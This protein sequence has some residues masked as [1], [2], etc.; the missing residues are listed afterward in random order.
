[1]SVAAIA[2]GLGL[3]AAPAG[4]A[5]T[6]RPKKPVKKVVTRTP[7]TA[8]RATTAPA[9]TAPTTTAAKPAAAPADSAPAPV[10]DPAKIALPAMDVTDV[11]TGKPVAL[12]SVVDGK[13]P[14]LVWFWAPH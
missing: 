6:T 4:A 11:R 2:V 12:R 9:T 7:T 10:L 8:R 14:V 3:A 1:V 13:L 5:T